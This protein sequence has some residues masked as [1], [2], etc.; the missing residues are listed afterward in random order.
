[1]ATCSTIAEI[2]R[3]LIPKLEIIAQEIEE[4]IKTK[5]KEKIQEI[6]YNA[7]SPSMYNRTGEFLESWGG[8]TYQTGEGA[9]AMFEYQ[10]D[11]LSL[12]SADPGDASYGQHVSVVTG[13]DVRNALAYI[14]FK[15]GAYP[16]WGGGYWSSPRDAW[17]ALLQIVGG[18]DMRKWVEAGAKKAGLKIQ[19]V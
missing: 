4:N 9:E 8:E 19:W 7:G 6:V 5:N 1:M 17:Q 2:Q 3:F 13:A 10:P 14:I 18:A 12:G 11:K 16:L 15:S